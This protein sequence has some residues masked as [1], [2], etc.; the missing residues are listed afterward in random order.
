M[1]L[2]D[3]GGL[4]LSSVEAGVYFDIS[5]RGVRGLVAWPV[6]GTS[7]FLALDRNANGR[8]DDGSE[9]FGNSTRLMSGAWASHGYEALREFDS[10]GDGRITATDPIYWYLLLWSDAQRNGTCAATEL[11]TVESA[12]ITEISLDARESRRHDEWGNEFRFRSLV[13]A[14]T[15]PNVRYSYDVFLR[16]IYQNR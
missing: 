10:N 7:A 15:P 5:A 9:L 6:D 11:I 3:P 16:V 1:I 8:I 13:R 2:L 4:R 14:L 12:G